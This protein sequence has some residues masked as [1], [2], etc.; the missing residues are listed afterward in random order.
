[1]IHLAGLLLFFSLFLRQFLLRLLGL[2]RT[3]LCLIF[4]IL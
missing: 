3:V 2:L 1:L 4:L